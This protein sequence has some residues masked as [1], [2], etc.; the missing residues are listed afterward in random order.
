MASMAVKAQST[1]GYAFST[2]GSF[3]SPNNKVTA[4]FAKTYNDSALTAID[5]VLGDFSNDV[6]VDGHYA[7]VHIGRG[8]G[9]P[10]GEDRIYKYDL[11][12]PAAG[13]LDSSMA[14]GGI[15]KMKVL[16]N[17]LVITRGFP[18]TTGF[19]QVIDKNNLQNVWYTDTVIANNCVGLQIMNNKA[20]AVSTQNN[21]GT[22]HVIGLDSGNWANEGHYELDSLSAGASQL[23]LANNMAYITGKRYDLN[24]NFLYAGVSQL[25]LT[26]STFTTDTTALTTAEAMAYR[27]GML[28]G[29]FGN[30]VEAY[31]LADG[32]RTTAIQEPSATALALSENDVLAVMSTDYFS[33]G[34]L[35]VYDSTQTM[36]HQFDCNVSGTAVNGVINYAPIANDDSVSGVVSSPDTLIIDVL[37]NDFDSE[38]GLHTV[39]IIQNPIYGTV[40]VE[41]GM[42]LYMPYG[43][44]T[45]A[46]DSFTYAAVDV[47]GALSNEAKVKVEIS[48]TVS[49]NELNQAQLTVYPNP[50]NHIIMVKGVEKT[51][52]FTIV[53]LAGVSVLSGTINTQSNINVEHLPKGV[54]LLVA[55]SESSHQVIRFVK[56]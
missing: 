44:T 13:V 55:E 12:N 3:G 20:Y 56:Q 8:Y 7:Y 27:D 31:L 28:I 33:F 51:T 36:T 21:K 32:T 52:N 17:Q 18:A 29:N 26:D 38:N 4:Y 16:D 14:V 37:A 2:G 49:V 45:N 47:W 39:Q 1:V 30:P 5:S 19:V 10:S 34:S 53:N 23:L 6:A 15:Q 9:H 24:W 11:S 40:A 54:Y 41:N 50:A 25:N 46:S 42:V 22:L 48:E 43:S 35:K